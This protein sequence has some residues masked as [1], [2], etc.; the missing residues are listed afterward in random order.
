[1]VFMGICFTDRR[2]LRAQHS[3]KFARGA[4]VNTVQEVAVRDPKSVNTS[5][6]SEKKWLGISIQNHSFSK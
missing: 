4:M 1:M 6:I 2:N 3:G 5:I